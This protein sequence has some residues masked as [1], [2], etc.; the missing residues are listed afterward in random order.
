MGRA[1]TP[2]PFF[3]RKH[4]EDRR[5][6]ERA[7]ELAGR[8]PASAEAMHFYISIAGH[9]GERPEALLE[10]ARRNAGHPLGE[11]L[12]RLMAAPAAHEGACIPLLAVRRAEGAS[13]LCGVCFR[14]TPA[15]SGVCARCGHSPIRVL[16]DTE[17][18]HIAIEA[19]D[20]CHACLKVVDLTADP[21]AVPEVDDLASVPLDLRAAA[22]GYRRPLPNLFGL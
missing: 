22:L 4:M 11:F 3:W 20:A 8:Y 14:E 15:A 13:L 6:I 17:F 16:E 7:E 12:A 2:A 9:R 5:R 10:A 18:P 19:C 1:A 21:A